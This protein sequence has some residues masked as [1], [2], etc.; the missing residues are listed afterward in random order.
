LAKHETSALQPEY[1]PPNELPPLEVPPVEEAAPLPVPTGLP[2]SDWAFPPHPT[3][4]KTSRSQ[5]GFWTM[6]TP[7][8]QEPSRTQARHL[9]GFSE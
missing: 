3:T 4:P 8:K 5:I 1:V 2:A 7:L 9:Q 6:I